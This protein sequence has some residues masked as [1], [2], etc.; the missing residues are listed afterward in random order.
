[1][2]PPQPQRLALGIRETWFCIF[3]G[4]ENKHALIENAPGDACK[5]DRED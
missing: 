2:T 3:Y 5:V 4:I 1:M